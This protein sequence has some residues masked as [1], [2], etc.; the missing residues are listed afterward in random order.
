[1]IN[2]DSI[3]CGDA[4]GFSKY[5]KAL[6]LRPYSAETSAKAIERV[7]YNLNAGYYYMVLEMFG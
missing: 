2:P 3:S 5:T 7:I 6:T 1:M 4:I